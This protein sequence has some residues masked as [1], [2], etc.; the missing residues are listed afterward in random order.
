MAEEESIKRQILAMK[1]WGVAALNKIKAGKLKEA[2][3]DSKRIYRQGRRLYRRRLRHLPKLKEVKDII[4]KV[5]EAEA[6]AKDLKKAIKKKN[7]DDME[8]WCGVIE[9]CSIEAGS[10]A[11]KQ[12][13]I[14]PESLSDPD[15]ITWLE[16]LLKGE[17]K[18]YGKLEEAAKVSII[19]RVNFK[20]VTGLR[21]KKLKGAL[22]RGANLSGVDFEGGKLEGANLSGANL[23]EANFEKA[24]LKEA[25]LQGAYLKKGNFRQTDFTK[26]NLAYA[27]AD[28]GVFESANFFG[29]NLQGASFFRANLEI[30]NLFNTNLNSTI[31]KKANLKRASFDGADFKGADLEKTDI[32]GANFTE[33]KNLTVE[34]LEVAENW[35]KA[36]NLPEYLKKSA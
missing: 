26:A 8:K 19:K 14:N 4:K 13:W 20:E 36:R 7:T 35:D 34:Q 15:N 18:Y 10:K 17:G 2:K 29:A 9:K 33:V 25:N 12:P 3:K 6:A 24:N 32:E 27:E 16:M 5:A 23:T 22:L 21:F 30:A 11:K 31:F 28:K 1:G